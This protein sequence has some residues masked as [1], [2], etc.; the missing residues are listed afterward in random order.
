[1][2]YRSVVLAFLLT[3]TAALAQPATPTRES[4]EKQLANRPVEAHFDLPYAGNSNPKQ[5]LDLYL[6]KVRKTDKPLPVVAYI[7]GGGWVHG[8][9]KGAATV[10]IRMAS[11]GNYAGVS[12]GY[13]LSDEAKW[14]AQIHDCK[15]AIRWLRGH[16]KEYNLDP[17]RIA[18]W[19]TSAGGHLVSLLGTTADVNELNGDLG[20][21]PSLSNKV[22]CVVNVCGPED[23]SEPLMQGAAAKQDDPALVGLFGGPLKDHAAE[24]KA[25]SPLTYVSSS[26]APFL[27]V[28]G[29]KD[30]RVNFTNSQKIDAALRKAGVASNLIGVEGGGHSFRSSEADKEIHQFLDL[31]LRGISAEIVSRTVPAEAVPTPPPATPAAKS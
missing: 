20:E 11:T 1:M 22:T 5:A 9:R 21:F 14:P 15:A 27:N 2:T 17:D 26:S 7:H 3:A 4:L 13:R 23:L 24:I 30:M 29:T 6:P 31:H 19:G 18:V 25:A 12:I 10:G 16:A 28:Q 8:D